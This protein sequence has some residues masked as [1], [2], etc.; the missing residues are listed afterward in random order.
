MRREAKAGL[1]V[2]QLNDRH[3][4]TTLEECLAF[5]RPLL[6]ENIEEEVDPLLDSVLE[7]RYLRKGGWQEEMAVT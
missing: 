7:R 4:R 5:G 1:R 3:F 2:T 6:I